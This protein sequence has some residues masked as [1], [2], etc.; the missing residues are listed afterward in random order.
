MNIKNR[1]YIFISLKKNEF[2]IIKKEWTIDNVLVRQLEEFR[3][4]GVIDKNGLGK[5]EIN[6]VIQEIIKIVDYL[7]IISLW[8]DK[9]SRNNMK[10]RRKKKKTD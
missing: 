4:L 9:T 10:K 6:Y 8:W 2:V 3:W 1:A 7:I 5:K